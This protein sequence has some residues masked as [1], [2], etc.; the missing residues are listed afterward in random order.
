MLNHN[1]DLGGLLNQL[2]KTLEKGLDEMAE[3]FD[4]DLKKEVEEAKK[5]GN[6]NKLKSILEDVRDKHNR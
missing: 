6:Y 2:K 1:N 4:D 3:H 5:T